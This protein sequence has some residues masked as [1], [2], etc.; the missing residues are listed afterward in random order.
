ME[1]NNITKEEFV[2]PI[3]EEA[4]LHKDWRKGQAIFNAVDCIYGLAR[5]VQFHCGVDCFF[6]DEKI[7]DFINKTYESYL[8]LCQ[9]QK[10]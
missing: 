2:K 9:K 5:Y 4:N 3:Y 8:E 7:D 1:V 6:N 10:K